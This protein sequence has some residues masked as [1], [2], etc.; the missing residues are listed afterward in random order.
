[1]YIKNEKVFQFLRDL[2][3][4][5]LPAFALLFATMGDIWKWPYN[6]EIAASII[7]IDTFIGACL[8][9]STNQYMKVTNGGEDYE[10]KSGKNN[11]DS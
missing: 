6:D 1:M 11:S 9:V 4:I 2:A 3:Q 5:Y 8:K 7:A 10:R